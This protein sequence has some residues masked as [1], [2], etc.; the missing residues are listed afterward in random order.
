MLK[1]LVIVGNF[2]KF[3][4]YLVNFTIL[5]GHFTVFFGHSISQYFINFLFKSFL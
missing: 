3:G 4:N 1:L 2:G 5:F